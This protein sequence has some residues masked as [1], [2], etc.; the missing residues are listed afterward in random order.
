[1]ELVVRFK[2]KQKEYLDDFISKG[3]YNT[4]SEVI[5]AGVL[6][7]VNKYELNKEPTKE[8]NTTR[9]ELEL[10]GKAIEEGLKKEKKLYSEKDLFKMFPHLK[11]LK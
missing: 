1:M 5:R 10:V 4:K 3:Y 8:N 9:K 6:E 11:K 2:G 7:L